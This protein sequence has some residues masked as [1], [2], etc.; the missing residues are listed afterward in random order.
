MEHGDPAQIFAQGYAALKTAHIL[1][2]R[3]PRGAGGG[4]PGV[5]HRP[6]PLPLAAGLLGSQGPA[7]ALGGHRRGGAPAPAPG[8]L[9]RPRHRPSPLSERGPRPPAPGVDR[10]D[11]RTRSRRSRQGPPD[12]PAGRRRGLLADRV[13][14][15]PARRAAAAPRAAAGGPGHRGRVHPAGLRTVL[16]SQ[17]AGGQ[18]VVELRPGLRRSAFGEPG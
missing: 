1:A 6:V 10:P 3:L 14:R 12:P 5:D 8:V 17:D 18:G 2:A 11:L 9:L 4:H 7:P 16:Q 13:E 15:E